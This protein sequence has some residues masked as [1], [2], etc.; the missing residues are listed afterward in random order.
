[1]NTSIDW[2][3][4]NLSSSYERDQNILEPYDFDTLLLEI[5]C[6]L[7]DE[8]LTAHDIRKHAREVI[9]AKRREALEILEANLTN[10]VNKAIEERNS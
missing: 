7:R 10:I 4:V 1:M 3:N 8:Q 2:N 5:S 6:N 9:N